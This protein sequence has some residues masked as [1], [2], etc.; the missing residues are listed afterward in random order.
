MANDGDIARATCKLCIFGIQFVE[1]VKMYEIGLVMILFGGY[2]L[3]DMVYQCC[4][5]WLT[6]VV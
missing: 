4:R 5:V 3:Y 1:S 6:G 2:V